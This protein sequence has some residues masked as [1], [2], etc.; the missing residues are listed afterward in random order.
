MNVTGVFQLGNEASLQP[1]D[2]TASLLVNVGGRVAKVG[3]S[4]TV[5]ASLVAPLASFSLGRSGTWTGGLCVDRIRTGRRTRFEC[6]TSTTTTTSSTSST[7]AS[8]T[9]STT[10]SATASSTTASTSSTTSATTSSSTSTSATASSSTSTSA[11]ASS[12]TSTSTTASTSS[13]T[14]ASATTSTATGPTT[15]VTTTT[16]ASSTSTA[17]TTTSTTSPASI[18]AGPDQNGRLPA[19]LPG[20]PTITLTGTVR[21]F[22]RGDQPGGHPDFETAY[23]SLVTGL[24]EPQI[25]ADR[26]PVLANPTSGNGDIQSAESFHEWFHDTPGVNETEPLPITLTRQPSGFYTLEVDGFFP[27]DDQLFGNQGL[28]HNYHFTFEVHSQFTYQPGRTFSFTGDDDVW[29]FINGQLVVD[30]GGVHA[31]AS[32][33]VALDTLGLTPGNTYQLDFFF[34][35]RHTVQSGFR[36]DTDLVLEDIPSVDV[37]LVGAVVGATSPL[38]TQ[39]SGPTTAKILTPSSLTTTVRFFEAG[40]YVFQ[41]QATAGANLLTDQVTVVVEA[42]NGSP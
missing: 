24:V 27:I 19:Q 11:T 35:E 8:T 6:G 26:T 10:T 20:P 30:L 40:T 23:T 15:T 31:A 41:L 9:S 14:T 33:S 13:S 42:P 28:E 12:S 38:W 29:V 34:A 36:L 1:E 39:V 21:D 7:T 17:T 5:E 25:G 18:D 37:D 16:N 3:A 4:S 2:A 22:K 32:G